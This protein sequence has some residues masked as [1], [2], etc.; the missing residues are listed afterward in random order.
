MKLKKFVYV[1][2]IFRKFKKNDYLKLKAY[3]L[4]IILNILNNIL[5]TMIIV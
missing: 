4:I 3:K 5:E 1:I 2:I